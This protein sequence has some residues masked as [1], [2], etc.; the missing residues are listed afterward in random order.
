MGY[1]QLVMIK[2]SPRFMLERWSAFRMCSAAGISGRLSEKK[3]DCA[4]SSFLS[5][6]MNPVGRG[7]GGKEAKGAALQCAARREAK[8]G[9][10]QA[11]AKR[12]FLG[13]S[14]EILRWEGG[15]KKSRYERRG[16]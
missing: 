2:M 10:R 8:D 12:V 9:Q 5:T 6:T 16:F 4:N 13:A 11:G 7:R 15:S 3:S 14:C 1:S